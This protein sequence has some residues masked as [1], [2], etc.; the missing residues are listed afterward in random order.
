MSK[1]VKIL[2]KLNKKEMNK[3]V[4]S[5]LFKKLHYS[6]DLTILLLKLKKIKYNKI[7][8]LYHIK[9]SSR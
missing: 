9:F 4:I 3:V 2:R 8:L 6:R 5:F 7:I 1:N